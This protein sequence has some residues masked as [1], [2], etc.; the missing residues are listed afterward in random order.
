MLV[1]MKSPV[2]ICHRRNKGS[3]EAIMMGF[4]GG[5]G[6]M[7]GFPWNIFEGKFQIFF[8]PTKKKLSTFS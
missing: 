5:G 3:A 7:I 6:G 4:G 8:L 2:G 1:N